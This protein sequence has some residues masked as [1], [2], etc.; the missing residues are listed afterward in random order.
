[1]DVYETKDELVVSA[2]LPSV[3][4]KEIQVTM[5]GDLLTIKGER[6]QERETKE[7]NYHRLERFFGKFERSIPVPV[8]VEAGK[9]KATYRNGVLEIHLPKAEAVKPKEIKIDVI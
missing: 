5:T 9:I 3:N 1:M 2:E 7:E 4:E 6:H 8:P